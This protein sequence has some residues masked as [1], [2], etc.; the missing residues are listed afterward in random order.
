MVAGDGPVTGRGVRVSSLHSE[1]PPRSAL[2]AMFFPCLPHVQKHAR[3]ETTIKQMEEVIDPVAVR[4]RD[5]WVKWVGIM[6][7]V[8]G[9]NQL[10]PPHMRT[11]CNIRYRTG[12]PSARVERESA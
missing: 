11:K 12:A 1:A 5:S 3:F 10:S 4:A 9:P 6:V 8:A 2:Y 7:A